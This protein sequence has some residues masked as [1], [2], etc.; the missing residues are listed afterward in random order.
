MAS[1][2]ITTID[3]KKRGIPPFYYRKLSCI[4]T[5]DDM[6]TYSKSQYQIQ[7]V[8]QSTVRIPYSLYVSN[9]GPLTV[10]NKD[11]H[12]KV[13]WNQQ[14]DRMEP[15][16]QKGFVPTGHFTSMNNKHFSVTSSKPGSQAPNGVGVDIK[17]NSYERYLNKR[18]GAILN[19]ER[20]PITFGL[21]VPYNPAYPVHGNKTVKTNIITGCECA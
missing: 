20:V 1:S 18:K 15:S 9:L 4:A 11:M 19:A 21:P 6:N 5:D 3:S 8:I 12:N 2:L 14:S 13:G 10:R 17:H 7:K 16:V